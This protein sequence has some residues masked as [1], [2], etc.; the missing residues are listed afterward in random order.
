M[1]KQASKVLD[2]ALA[3]PPDARAALADSLLD[4]LDLEVDEQAEYNWREEVRKRISELD[5][6]VVQA[7][8]WPEVRTRLT[9]Q[10][11]R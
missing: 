7:V 2:Q 8:P 10:I 9:G 11:R 4:S 1:D 3:L 6:G 5:S